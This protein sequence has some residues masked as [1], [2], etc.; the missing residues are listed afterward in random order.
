MSKHIWYITLSAFIQF[1]PVC[2]P[3]CVIRL[4]FFEKS[5]MM[6]LQMCPKKAILWKNLFTLATISLPSV[7][8]GDLYDYHFVG[9]IATIYT[10]ISF[11]PK[12]YLMFSMIAIREINIT[13][14]KIIKFLPGMHPHVFLSLSFCEKEFSHWLFIFIWF[15]IITFHWKIFW[16]MQYY[17][18]LENTHWRQTISMQLVY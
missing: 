2:V 14:A 6:H 16:E 7:F 1:S 3:I 11:I 4:C 9:K 17:I 10:M 8:L 15:F 5:L 12:M 13:L 18:P